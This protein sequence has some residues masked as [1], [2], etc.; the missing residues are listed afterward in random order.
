MDATNKLILAFVTLIVGLV[1]VSQIAVIGNAATGKTSVA[2]ESHIIVKNVTDINTTYVYTITNYPTGWKT[3]DCPITSVTLSNSSG[4]AFT[5]TTDYVFTAAA[6]TF[7]LKNTSAVLLT[8]DNLTYVDY[9]YCG[10]D[11]LNL[12]WGRTFINLVPG[13]FALTLLLVSVGLFWSVAKDYGI[14]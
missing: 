2:D 1:F 12:S 3:T 14:M 9:I 5:V 6:G 13:F 10:D 4:T 8:A 7:T 11:Y